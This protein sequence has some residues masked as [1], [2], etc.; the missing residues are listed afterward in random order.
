M[1]AGPSFQYIVALRAIVCLT[2]QTHA[3]AAVHRERRP[4]E[5]PGQM[6]ED[7]SGA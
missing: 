3:A 2:R 7:H 6:I 1:K 5:V 4:A